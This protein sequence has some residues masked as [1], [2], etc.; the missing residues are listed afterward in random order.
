MTGSD[1]GSVILWDIA[2]STTA[3]LIHPGASNSS[4]SDPPTPAM[5]LPPPTLPLAQLVEG[6]LGSHGHTMWP[7]WKQ[8]LATHLLDHYVD[9]IGLL[10]ESSRSVRSAGAGAELPSLSTS[11]PFMSTLLVSSP[12]L[13]THISCQPYRATQKI[14]SAVYDSSSVGSG[15]SSLPNSPPLSPKSSYLPLPRPPPAPSRLRTFHGHGGPVWAVDCD[16]A[17]GWMVSG[18]YDQ[19]VKVGVLEY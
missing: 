13:S 6:G 10:C 1:D 17:G 8:R 12:H 19:C 2:P 15:V 4:S 11:P 3:H 18:S 7:S 9:S 14:G 16:D 5:L